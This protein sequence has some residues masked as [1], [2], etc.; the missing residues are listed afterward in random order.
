M[1]LRTLDE[2]AQLRTGLP[3]YAEYCA[4]VRHRLIPGVW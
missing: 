4:K 3:G 1:V 2:E